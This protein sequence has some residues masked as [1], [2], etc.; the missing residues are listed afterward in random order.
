MPDSNI[1]KDKK[2]TEVGLYLRSEAICVQCN[3]VRS[4]FFKRHLTAR[5]THCAKCNDETLWVRIFN[6]GH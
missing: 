5:L 3:T 4:M 1:E 2:P 6:R